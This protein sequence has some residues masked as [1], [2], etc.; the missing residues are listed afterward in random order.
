MHG[1]TICSTTRLAVVAFMFLAI[2]ASA[3]EPAG[4]RPPK[5]QASPKAG[6]KD[7]AKEPKLT[8][9]TSSAHC[10]WAWL[11]ARAW[12]EAR[13]AQIIHDVLLLM[14]KYPHYVWQLENENDELSPFLSKAGSQWPGMIDEFW[15]RVREGRIEVVNA[16]SDPQLHMPYPETFCPRPGVGQGVLPPPRPRASSS[17]S[18]TP[19]TCLSATRNC[20]RSWPTPTTSISCARATGQAVPVLADR[21]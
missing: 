4:G 3:A 19:G 10:D 13:Y 17:P 20:R 1:N 15:R 21:A 8:V 9:V 18:M 16:I 6:I 7:A 11:H 2:G 14:R 5:E 12:H